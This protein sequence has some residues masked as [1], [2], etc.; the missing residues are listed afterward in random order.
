MWTRL[1]SLLFVAASLLQKR[2]E[3]QA[4]ICLGLDG[5]CEKSFASS[6]IDLLNDGTLTTKLPL[7]DND[8]PD[9]GCVLCVPPGEFWEGPTPCAECLCFDGEISCGVVGP[10]YIEADAGA[11]PCFAS[12]YADFTNS[13]VSTTP[14]CPLL[15]SPE[16][17]KAALN[18]SAVDN[19]PSTATIGENLTSAAGN[20]KSATA[21]SVDP[22]SGTFSGPNASLVAAGL[23]SF[24]VLVRG[25]D[26]M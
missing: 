11:A 25:R 26:S 7:R 3:A 5:P 13:T 1:L 23:L 9:G 8:G 18:C 6:C 20:K 17:L 22:T 14:R 16:E 10:P 24:L 15:P 2:A 12:E 21:S 4:E 19:D